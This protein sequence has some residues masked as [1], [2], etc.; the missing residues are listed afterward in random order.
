MSDVKKVITRIYEF[1]LKN[2]ELNDGDEMIPTEHG[3]EG[4]KLGYL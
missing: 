1:D 4:A 2:C 3:N